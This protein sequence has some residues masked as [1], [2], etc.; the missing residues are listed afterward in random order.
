MRNSAVT[1]KSTP[2]AVGRARR[3]GV[4][5]AGV[6]ALA[7]VVSGCGVR[8]TSVPVDAGGA[9]SR[10]SCSPP[11][12]A[13]AAA[14]SGDVVPARVYLVCASGLVAVDRTVRLPGDK[15]QVGRVVLAQALLDALREQP[16]DTERQAGFTTYVQGTLSVSAGRDGDPAGAL[17]LSRQ[18]EDLPPSALAQL[19]CTYAEYEAVS[20]NG[21]AVLGGPGD[22]PVRRYVC[23]R[24]VKERPESP[25]PTRS[26]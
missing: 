13:S 17:R 16:S 5:L 8:T 18:P 6:A 12:A 7:A 24:S 22:Y 14:E 15:G 1:G 25:V 3:W 23:D 4:L 19:V 20:V 9:P 10:M 2:E 21:T 11:P 26:S